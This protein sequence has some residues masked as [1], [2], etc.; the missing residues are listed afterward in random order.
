MFS[1]NIIKGLLNKWVDWDS[2][3]RDS[4]TGDGVPALLGGLKLCVGDGKGS[5]LI[6]VG[7]SKGYTPVL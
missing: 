7:N 6:T 4:P 2:E 5:E 1:C 3:E